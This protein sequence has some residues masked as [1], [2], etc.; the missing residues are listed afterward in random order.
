[1]GDGK[2]CMSIAIATVIYVI[3]EVCTKIF[4]VSDSKYIYAVAISY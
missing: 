4:M 2:Y 1:M 3:M